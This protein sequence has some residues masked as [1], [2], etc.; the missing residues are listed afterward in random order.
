VTVTLNHTIVWCR[1]KFMSARYLTDTLGLQ[2]ASPWGPFMVVELGNGVSL[3]YHDSDDPEGEIASQHYAFLV[4]ES[5][6]GEIFARLRAAGQD[7]WADPGLNR[8]GQINGNDG[9]RGV[10]FKDPDGHLLEIIT[11]PY[12]S[13]ERARRAGAVEGA[14]DLG[15]T[16]PKAAP[17]GLLDEA[18]DQVSALDFEIPNPFVNHAPMACEALSALGF[19]SAINE[20]VEHYEPTVHR[21]T[22][23]IT[24]TWGHEFSWKDLVG[25][26][27][28]LPEWMG[29]FE[30]AIDDDGWRDVVRTWVPRLMPGQVSALFHGVIRTSHAARALDVTDTRSRRAEL[31][32]ALGNWACWFEPGQP[33]DEHFVSGDP[34]IATA[35]A[36]ARAAGCY[37]SQPNVFALHGVTGGMAVHL[38]SGYLD[39]SDATSALSQ[40][41]AEYR[42]LHHD[43]T[44][45]LVGDTDGE[46]DSQFARTAVGSFDP[47]QVKLVEACRR[48]LDLTGDPYYVAA[49]RLVTDNP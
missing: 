31:A 3:D 30:R 41:E 20:W 23:P 39:P 44:P 24:P 33:T 46:W 7:Y 34:G 47:H 27:W 32:R 9:G 10:Y 8:Q 37:V 36:A 40:L 16:L 18:F 35:Q 17:T 43:I 22:Q 26:L 6:F 1:D 21:P 2:E 5:D 38:L 15:R 49:A 11:R 19:D 14:I 42:V 45:A 29:Y 48:G 28:L 4:S 13:G 12:G 25:D